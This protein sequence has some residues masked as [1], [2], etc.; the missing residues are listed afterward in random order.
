VDSTSNLNRPYAGKGPLKTAWHELVHEMQPV[1]LAAKLTLLTLLFSHVGDWTVRPL[2]LA[3]AGFALLAPGAYRSSGIWLCLA[4]LTGWRVWSDWP[5]ADNHAYLLAYWCFALAI[6]FAQSE[7]E[8]PLAL[9]A[10]ILIGLVFCFAAVQ[11]GLTA[12]YVDGTFFTTLFLLDDRFEDLAVLLT[13]LDYQDIYEA[14]DWLESALPSEKPVDISPLFIPDSL[15]TLSHFSTWWNLL[16]QVAVGIAFLS[17]LGSWAYRHREAFLLLF[18][19]TTYAVAPVPSFGWLL[20]S[21]AVAQCNGAGN[22]AK[23]VLV[24]GLLAAYYYVPWAAILVD[25]LDIQA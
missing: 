23:Y 15:R 12:N 16:E 4:M 22:R 1:E 11:K 19:I 21:M 6:S 13:S 20:I 9:N 5:L 3:L 10:R 8:K 24:Y 17:P 25:L 2:V 14:R 18:C 7:S